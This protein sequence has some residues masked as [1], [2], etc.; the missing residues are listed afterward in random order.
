MI[1]AG[2]TWAWTFPTLG[3]VH[4]HIW[5]MDLTDVSEALL[6]HTDGC[7]ASQLTPASLLAG[8]SITPGLLYIHFNSKCPQTALTPA[9]GIPAGPAA[10]TAL[11]QCHCHHPH[12][13]WIFT[14][15]ISIPYRGS[16]SCSEYL[17]VSAP[18]HSWSSHTGAHQR[19]VKSSNLQMH[20]PTLFYYFSPFIHVSTGHTA[21]PS[22]KP[23]SA[24]TSPVL[25]R[26]SPGPWY[27]ET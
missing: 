18:Q 25:Q 8:L 6:A 16:R 4:K 24:L 12:Q 5:D 7:L 9:P 13:Y 11:P 19:M 3:Y 23:G 26:G 21:Q 14:T 22:H 20:L 10:A 17:Q 2:A 15:S 27:S 1:G